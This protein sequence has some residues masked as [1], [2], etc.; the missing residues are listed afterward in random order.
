MFF[1]GSVEGYRTSKWDD[2]YSKETGNKSDS[3]IEGRGVTTLFDTDYPDLRDDYK[4]QSEVKKLDNDALPNWIWGAWAVV[5]VA[6]AGLLATGLCG[7]FDVGALSNMG[8][9]AY[10]P[11][12]VGA[13]LMLMSGG[14]GVYKIATHFFNGEK[15]IQLQMDPRFELNQELKTTDINLKDGQYTVVPL[16]S[17]CY[18]IFYNDPDH[19][20]VKEYK[21]DGSNFDATIAHLEDTVGCTPVKFYRTNDGEIYLG[22][23]LENNAGTNALLG[24]HQYAIIPGW[25]KGYQLF[26]RDEEGAVFK[27]DDIH[28]DQLSGLSASFDSEYELYVLPAY[29]PSA[30]QKEV[31]DH[32]GLQAN[33]Y[34][35]V[36][37]GDDRYA[38]DVKIG[39]DAAKRL[40]TVH[41]E[42]ALEEQMAFLDEKYTRVKYYHAPNGKA[43]LCDFLN[44][45]RHDDLP[46]GE[47]LVERDWMEEG[48]YNLIARDEGEGPFYVAKC[49]EGVAIKNEIR[50]LNENGYSVSQNSIIKE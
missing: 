1:E 29:R 9:I 46:P 17:G 21:V 32:S 47:F 33:Q 3:K 34:V 13:G 5:G 48:K 43:R 11:I 37:L 16:G 12:G 50:R 36:P 31:V 19:E 10:L 49:I 7:H 28:R 44:T 22:R 45:A 18:R 15:E 23:Y 25:D 40:T 38:I 4:G 42:E 20:S 26:A 2:D 30:A 8:D 39:A 24:A 41:G 6:G 14:V 27:I 35:V